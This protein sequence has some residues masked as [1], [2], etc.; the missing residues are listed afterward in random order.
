MIFPRRYIFCK[1]TF[2]SFSTISIYDNTY[3]PNFR[4]Y[5]LSFEPDAVKMVTCSVLDSP[6]PRK[7]LS[8]GWGTFQKLFMVGFKRSRGN[9]ESRPKFWEPC[10]NNEIIQFNCFPAFKSNENG[11]EARKMG[12]T[13]SETSQMKIHT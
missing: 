7:F 5:Q 9:Y 1:I 11:L 10:R 13:Q 6:I 4:K 8:Y 2:I 3:F 12:F